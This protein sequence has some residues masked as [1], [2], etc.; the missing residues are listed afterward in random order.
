MHPD[1]QLGAVVLLERHP[2][3]NT[4][5]QEFLGCTININKHLRRG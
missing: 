3:L 4:R 1:L 2:Y 5:E